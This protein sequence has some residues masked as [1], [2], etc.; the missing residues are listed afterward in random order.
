M[1]V[2]IW[3]QLKKIN[4]YKNCQNIITKTDIF[5]SFVNISVNQHHWLIIYVTIGLL[6]PR[7]Y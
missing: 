2:N 3:T 5:F 1:N 7:V 4:I 6:G